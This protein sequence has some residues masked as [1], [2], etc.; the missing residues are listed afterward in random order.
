MFVIINGY[1]LTHSLR[2]EIDARIKEMLTITL[3]NTQSNNPLLVPKKSITEE[4]KLCIIMDFDA[5]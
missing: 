1:R 3:L 5:T 4:K 2:A